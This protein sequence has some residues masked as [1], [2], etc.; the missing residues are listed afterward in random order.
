[1]NVVAPRSEKILLRSCGTVALQLPVDIRMYRYMYIRIYVY[2]RTHTHI[3]IYIYTY[4][5]HLYT[6]CHS[7]KQKPTFK[8]IFATV[9]TR[10]LNGTYWVYPALEKILIFWVV[11]QRLLDP[12]QYEL[13][14]TYLFRRKPSLG[15]LGQVGQ[16][17]EVVY[18]RI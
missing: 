11:S 4:H 18:K 3:Y 12:I 14:N 17:G 7:M 6:I 2:T 13:L 10:T 5:L 1:M 15:G 9:Q 16:L 8:G